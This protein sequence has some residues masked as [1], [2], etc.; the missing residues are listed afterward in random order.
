MTQLKALKDMVQEAIDK[1]ATT[2]EEVHQMIASKPLEMLEQLIP[3]KTP[4]KEI[5]AFQKKTIGSVYDMIRAVNKAVG[6]IAG[7]LLDRIEKP[8]RGADGPSV[9]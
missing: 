1:G 9:S 6:E 8:T 7:N 2:V 3:D 4:A 5:E